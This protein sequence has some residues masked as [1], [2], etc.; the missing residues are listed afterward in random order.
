MRLTY[1]QI[2]V[3]IERY[4]QRHTWELKQRYKIAGHKIDDKPSSSGIV[5]SETFD[6]TT[7]EG[8]QAFM[9]LGIPVTKL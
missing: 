1:R 7:P 8:L 2:G 9:N 4:W 3:F 5:P 6:A